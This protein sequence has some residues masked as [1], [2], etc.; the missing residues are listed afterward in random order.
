MIGFALAI[1][2]LSAQDSFQIPAVTTSFNVDNQ[3]VHVTA[4]GV[5]TRAAREHGV[6]SLSLTAD[7]GDLQSNITALLRPQVERSERC[8]DRISLERAVLVPAAPSSLLTAYLHYEKW[9]CVKAFG[10]EMVKRLVGGNGTIQVKLTPE[11]DP[12]NA[13][14]LASEVGSIE[15]DGS[16]GEL[17]RS[18]SLGQSLRDK[19]ASSLQSAV[20]KATDHT[21]VLPPAIQDVATIRSA[22]FSDLG[23]GRL[24]MT[25]AGEVRLSEQDMR[26]VMERLNAHASK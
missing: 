17:L 23:A 18:G 13:V 3:P 21:T 5:V 6:F 16:L 1:A 26:F 22:R 12:G 20:Q 24:A 15:A 8:G 14:R 19:I 10:K 9:G 4:S 25:L 2:V 11:V 7:I